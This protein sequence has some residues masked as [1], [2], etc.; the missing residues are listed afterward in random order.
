MLNVLNTEIQ[1]PLSRGGYDRLRVLLLCIYNDNCWITPSL[2][3]FSPL[4]A[5]APFITPI[6]T[7]N[8]EDERKPLGSISFGTR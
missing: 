1:A 8:P 7:T 6:C 2:L 5:I 4:A 3:Q